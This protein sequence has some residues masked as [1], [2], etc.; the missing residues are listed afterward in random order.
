MKTDFYLIPS[1]KNILASK[2]IG[3]E[4]DLI[5]ID[6]V[7]LLYVCSSVWEESWSITHQSLK[8]VVEN[9]KDIIVKQKNLSA[10]ELDYFIEEQ[11]KQY[12][13]YSNEYFRRLELIK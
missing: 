10:K 5:Q 6:W 3:H 11:V 9:P 4:P 2:M 7:S 12:R 8:G 13:E 1:D